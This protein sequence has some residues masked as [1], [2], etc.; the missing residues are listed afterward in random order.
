MIDPESP[1]I[2]SPDPEA[3]TENPW[4]RISSSTK[5]ENPWF[6]VREDEVVKPDGNPGTYSVVS[7]A[8]LATGIVPLWADGSLTLVGQFRYP[9]D[10]YTWE[11]PEGGGDLRDAPI[12]IAKRELLEET[13][14]RARQWES[15]GCVHTSNCFVDE[16]CHL[17]LA[18]E[19]V[20]GEASPDPSEVIQIRNVPFEEAVAMAH[21]GR[22][23][24]S[25]TIA[26]IFRV[27]AR[28][29]FQSY[30]EAEPDH[31]GTPLP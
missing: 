27:L 4:K 26:G 28:L 23:T 2:E 7:A 1:P 25:I 13:G 29:Q 22:I 12:E 6:R 11:I 19:L 3:R 18:T 16:V 5:Y 14:V 17:F 15:L 21:D 31:A 20:Q 9:L 24:D 10:E 8:R 30:A